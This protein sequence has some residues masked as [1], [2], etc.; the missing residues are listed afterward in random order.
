M[1]ITGNALFKTRSGAGLSQSNPG[2]I[3]LPST[4]S[5]EADICMETAPESVFK[6][7]RR[8][9]LTVTVLS[10]LAHAFS[11]VEAE[12]IN[13]SFVV[14]ALHPSRSGPLQMQ[15]RSS[16][17]IHN[18]RQPVYEEVSMNMAGAHW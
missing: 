1:C 4:D 14:Q 10:K 15:R 2:L 3:A 17:V 12:T 18:I 16:P 11:G 9:N 6:A 7:V 13:S 8:L 5:T